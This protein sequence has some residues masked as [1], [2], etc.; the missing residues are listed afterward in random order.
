MSQKDKNDQQIGKPVQRQ[1]EHVFTKA[2]V[3][4]DMP[5]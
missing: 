5:D 2:S 1:K 4:M 3:D